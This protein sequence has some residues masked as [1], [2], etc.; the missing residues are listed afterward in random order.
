MWYDGFASISSVVIVFGSV[1]SNTNRR[2]RSSC[3]PNIGY[4]SSSGPAMRSIVKPSG[5]F[6]CSDAVGGACRMA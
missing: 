4:D 5:T 3:T 1:D 2:P 6:R